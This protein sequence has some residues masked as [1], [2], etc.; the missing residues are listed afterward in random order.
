MEDC[1]LEILRAKYGILVT[2][3]VARDALLSTAHRDAPNV[4]YM[5]TSDKGTQVYGRAPG[6]DLATHTAQRIADAVMRESTYHTQ[7][8]HT[9]VRERDV[10]Q[11]RPFPDSLADPA[12]TRHVCRK[13]GPPRGYAY[14]MAGR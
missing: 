14:N 3:Q 6:S 7:G 11:S 12:G 4:G 2:R 9:R 8:I 13:K 5:G 10:Y 1:V